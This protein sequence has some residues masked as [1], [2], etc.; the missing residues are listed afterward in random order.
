[1]S[2]QLRTILITGSTTGHGQA[3]AERLAGPDTLLLLHGRDEQRAGEVRDRVRAAGGQ[4]EV[5]LADLADLH[6]VD[7]LA[8][9]VLA[10]FPRLDVLVNNAGIGSG[11]PGAPR[12]QSADGLE[13]RLAVNYLAGYHL[14]TRL[15]GRLQEADGRIV[16]VSSIGQHPIDFADPQLL[17]DY[18]GG[19]AYRQAKLAQIL[20]TIDL[21]EQLTAAGSTVTV[22]AL[23]P[24]TLMPTGMVAEALLPT[25]SGVDEGATTTLA[26]VSGAAGAG[27]GRFYNGL[28]EARAD[29]QAYDPKAREQLRALSAELVRSVLG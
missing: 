6:E 7:G 10:D 3:L 27:T 24:A 23:H 1:M 15:L 20:H 12:E 22:N 28:Q 25:M 2:N 16:N 18:D 29:N 17:V 4:A 19:R 5:L 8:T 11:P 21:A 9:A 13:L 14:N 26:L